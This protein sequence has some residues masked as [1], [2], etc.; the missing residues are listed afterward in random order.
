M[1]ESTP[2]TQPQSY[3]A[4]HVQDATVELDFVGTGVRVFSATIPTPGSYEVYIDGKRLSEGVGSNPESGSQLLLG[5]I[6][7]LEMA[8]HTVT[9][10]NSGVTGDI[11]DL[12]RVEVESVLNTGRCGMS[13]LRRFAA[14]RTDRS[15]HPSLPQLSTTPS[16][17]FSG[18]LN[19]FPL[20]GLPSTT[21]PSSTY[22]CVARALPA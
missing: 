7:G 6:T 22:C 18:D 17:R 3:H 10:V 15:V 5:H 16:T 13:S 14:Y 8:P 12:D 9:L 21:V 11:L 2:L 1:A 19:G 20:D 4:T